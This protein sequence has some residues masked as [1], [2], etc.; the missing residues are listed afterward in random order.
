MRAIRVGYAFNMGRL[1]EA[2]RRFFAAK[3]KSAATPKRPPKRSEPQFVGRSSVNE[4][5]NAPPERVGELV[6]H[7]PERVDT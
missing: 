1:V 7:S 4:I 6:G 5:E 2:V 3:R